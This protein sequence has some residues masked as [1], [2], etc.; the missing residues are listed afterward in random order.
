MTSAGVLGREKKARPMDIL[1]PLCVCVFGMSRFIADSN[2]SRADRCSGDGIAPRRAGMEM[3]SRAGSRRFS[4]MTRIEALRAL[5]ECE[6]QPKSPAEKMGEKEKAKGAI[7]KQRER[8]REMLALPCKPGVRV[9]RERF[10]QLS[11]LA[12]K[13][14]ARDVIVPLRS[15]TW[16]TNE[17]YGA[18]M[19]MEMHSREVTVPR[20]NRASEWESSGVGDMRSRG[21][22]SKTHDT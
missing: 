16:S 8:A 9:R 12:V 7:E 21:Y 14:T 13:K 15:P 17:R 18:V 11:R 5:E 6:T 2:R 22:E 3:Q 10:P 19:D 4:A 1:M 20:R